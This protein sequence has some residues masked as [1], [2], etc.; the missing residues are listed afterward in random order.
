MCRPP[1]PLA[2]QDDAVASA[3]ASGLAPA[4]TRRTPSPPRRRIATAALG[5]L[6]LTCGV[7]GTVDALHR[8]AGSAPTISAGRLAIRM[9]TAHDGFKLDS[10]STDTTGSSTTGSSTDTS[11]TNS[12]ADPNQSGSLT[13]S[14]N[15]QA[16]TAPI[17]TDNDTPEVPNVVVLTRPENFWNEDSSS[18]DENIFVPLIG[19]IPAGPATD[20]FHALIERAGEDTTLDL[21]ADVP[22][23]RPDELLVPTDDEVLPNHNMPAEIPNNDTNNHVEGHH[24]R[25]YFNNEE[26][27]DAAELYFFHPRTRPVVDEP[28]TDEA[29][30]F[31]AI[32][33]YWY[34][35]PGQSDWDMQP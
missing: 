28:F 15:D 30:L 12:S 14:T 8:N 11:T 6:A 1:C 25:N 26:V 5:A 17:P 21:R 33:E 27:R 10:C 3:G 18:E 16:A 19:E 31:E 35:G 32:A 9:A 20:N 34:G 4:K 13:T 7:T 29:A 24:W 23:E 2:R 22:A